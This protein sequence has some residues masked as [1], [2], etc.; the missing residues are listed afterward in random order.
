MGLA[1][2]ADGEDDDAV[3]FCCFVVSP[4]FSIALLAAVFAPSPEAGGSFFLVV[5][6]M[7]RTFAFG[8]ALAEGSFVAEGFG[9]VVEPIVRTLAFGAAAAR[10]VSAAGAAG[11]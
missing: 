2:P 4:V 10:F 6:P 5:S 9:S 7:V 1:F 8:G 3:P 11:C